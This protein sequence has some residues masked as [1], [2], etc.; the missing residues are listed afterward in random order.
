[1]G[2]L[3]DYEATCPLDGTTF[4]Y[5]GTPGYSIFGRALDG[6]P[7]GSWR[8]PLE[9]PECP[10]CRFTAALGELTPGEADRA[11]D[12]IDSEAW[13]SAAEETS[14]W[15]LSLIETVL[16]R[17]TGWS[18]VDRL[19]SAT[20]Q[21]YGDPARY[22]RYVRAL[23]ETLDEVGPDLRAE[24][25]QAWSVLQSFVANAQRQAGDFKGAVL[26]L[27]ALEADGVVDVPLAERIA[28]TRALIASADTRRV[29]P[30]PAI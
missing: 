23:I 18:R 13:R 12:L 19:L 16:G 29:Q 21:A 3:M 24:R 22:G 5:A 26:R 10:R 1:M 17:A 7:Y 15:R 8:F 27:D 9:L 11:A 25:G 28:E 6:L 14:Y 30:A 20:W 4:T 2:I